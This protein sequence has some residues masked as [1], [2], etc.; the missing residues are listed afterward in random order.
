[1]GFSQRVLIFLSLSVGLFSVDKAHIT[2]LMQSSQTVPAF[3]LYTAYQKEIG[4]H[5]FELLQEMGMILLEKGVRSPEVE[6]QLL[7]LFGA[8]MAGVVSSIDIL[9]QG[10]KSP[11]PEVQQA[12]IQFLARLEDDRCDALLTKA[13][14]SPYFPIRMEAG[15]YL[16]HRKHQKAVGLLES[17][18]YK[19]PNQLWFYFPQF[20]ALIGT[21]DA[22]MLL[23]HLIEDPN[24]MVRVEAILSAARFGRDDFLPKIRA[25]ATHP[26]SDEQEAC[27]AA[28]G[29]LKDSSSMHRLGK[30]AKSPLAHVKLAALRSLYTLGDVSKLDPILELARSG[31]LWAVAMLGEF[32]VAQPVLEELVKHTDFNIRLNAALGLLSQRNPVCLPMI[33]ELLIRDVR[34]LGF[35]PM[36][37]V[38]HSITA[39]KAVFS[40]EHH[41]KTAWFDLNAVSMGLRQ[42]ILLQCLELPEAIFLEIAN[43]ILDTHQTELIPPLMHL[44]ENHQTEEAILLL[45]RKAQK[46]GS[47]LVRAFCSL[48]LYRMRQEGPYEAY[49][50]TWLHQVKATEMIRFKP[51]PAYDKRLSSS[52]F[53]LTPEE[54]SHL[55]IEA[56]QSLSE[57]HDEAA[58]D[59]LLDALREGNPKN[60]PVLAGLLIH[61]LQ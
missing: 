9:E 55:L 32:P 14:A 58:I 56:Y 10:V 57:R 3:D 59:L 26:H 20:F 43:L 5:D 47:P 34:D 17:L 4:R 21:S 12:S 45:K 37:S 52:P 25:H 39:W 23:Q 51:S 42:Q 1:M 44:L 27:A 16:A 49:V 36:T 22:M 29:M 19:V 30:L 13:M 41:L 11:Q 31:D 46:A 33:K 7:S 53:E 38:G 8:S 15:Y 18:M 40:L 61:A 48:T 24:S 54:R 35:Q 2:F 50:R 6:S 60:R 28:L